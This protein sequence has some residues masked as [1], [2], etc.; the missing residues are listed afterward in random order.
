MGSPPPPG[1]PHRAREAHSP[2]GPLGGWP[3]KGSLPQH[4]VELHF[5]A[6]V[7]RVRVSL[8]Q[9]RR[10]R[11]RV[12]FGREHPSTVGLLLAGPTHSAGRQGREAPG[13]G[14]RAA[15]G[16]GRRRGASQPVETQ[17]GGVPSC[18]IKARGPR[19]QRRGVRGAQPAAGARDWSG[20]G[21]NLAGRAAQPS[22]SSICPPRYRPNSTVPDWL[23]GAGERAG[24]PPRA[25]ISAGAGRRAGLSA[26]GRS[27]RVAR[28]GMRPQHLPS[29][30]SRAHVFPRSLLR[31]APTSELGTRLLCDGLGVTP[32]HLWVGESKGLGSNNWAWNPNSVLT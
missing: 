6:D 10:G 30:T 16:C 28:P 22:A 13:E 15:G 20:P 4:T 29:P 12:G 23:G 31:A 18:C 19:A 21:G 9:G 2:P 5:G 24:G 14:G 17:S 1:G 26:S 11:H 8:L 32:A 3:P 7:Q 25:P 27:P